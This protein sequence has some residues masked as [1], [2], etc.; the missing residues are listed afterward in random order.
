MSSRRQNHEIT[1]VVIRG[2]SGSGKSTLAKEYFVKR[3][4][5]AFAADDYM[6]DKNGDYCFSGGMLKECHTRCRKNARRALQ[7]GSDVVVHNT[8]IKK[9]DIQ[10]YY[11]ISKGYNLIILS[12][13][14]MYGS[15]KDIPDYVAL[16]HVKEYEAVS[17]ER[18]VV[19]DKETNAILDFATKEV[20]E[21][22]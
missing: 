5:K 14:S 8:T 2:P 18:K 3:G 10:P 15:D 22:K 17:G 6:V 9:M 7:K 20:V 21:I 13:G 12:M 11:D 16:R 1:L 19:Y 4:Y